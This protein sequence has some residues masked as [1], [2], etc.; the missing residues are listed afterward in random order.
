MRQELAA[1]EPPYETRTV[2]H[3]LVESENEAEEILAELED[4]E[5]F[6]EL[7]EERSIDPGSGA[8]GGEL[9]SFPRGAYVPEFDDAAWDAEIDE[10]V[11]PVETDFGFHIIQ[12]T[13][14]ESTPATELDVQTLDELVGQ[15]LGMRI[16]DA[17]QAAEIEV[18]PSLGRWDATAGEVVPTDRVGD[19]SDQ[20]PAPEEGF[21]EQPGLDESIIEDDGFDEGELDE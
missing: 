18:D 14:A 15:E 10:I 17:F 4:G 2:R 11:G 9:G 12:V 3:I 1:D 7:A 20:Q 8:Q 16:N 21:G 5:D 6:A 13:A 19:G